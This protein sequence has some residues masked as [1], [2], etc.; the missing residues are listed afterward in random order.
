MLAFS[1]IGASVSRSL[2]A[3]SAKAWPERPENSTVKVSRRFRTSG[4][5]PTA[6][7]SAVN[8]SIMIFSTPI[9]ATHP[10]QACTWK[11]LKRLGDGRNIRREGVALG[12]RDGECTD[13]PSLDLFPGG[14]EVIASDPDLAAD[15]ILHLLVRRAVRDASHLDTGGLHQ[16]LAAQVLARTVAGCGVRL[17]WIGLHPGDELR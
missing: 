11:P 15:E 8:S 5:W 6:F 16:H 13:F 4:S 17:I 12:R 3:K 2:R 14:R 10:N 7:S 9:G 1:T